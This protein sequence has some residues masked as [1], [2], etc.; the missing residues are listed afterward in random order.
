MRTENLFFDVHPKIVPA[1]QLAKITIRPRYEHVAFPDDAIYRVSH[2]HTE[3]RGLP[4][5]KKP[6]SIKKV[7]PIKGC[8]SFTL[9]F[10]DEQ[11]HVIWVERVNGDERKHVG[12]FRIYSLEKD[13]LLRTPYKGD[14]HI[15]SVRSDG[16]ESPAYVVGAARRIG[17]DFIAVTDHRRY[18]PSLEA[19][20]AFAQAPVDMAIF[21]GEEVH[22]PDN[23]VH[24]I[25]YAG[26]ASINAMFNKKRAYRSAVRQLQQHLPSVPNGVDPYQYASTVWCFNTIREVGGLGVFCHPYWFTA[27]RYTPAGPLT[28]YL[29][30]TQP[31]DAYEVIGGFFRFEADSNTLQVARYHEERAKGRI[32][33]I[34][35]A[36]DAHGCERGELFGWY[37]SIVFSPSLAWQDLRKSIMNLYSVAVEALPNEV[38]RAYGPFRLVKY[39]L[40]LMREAMPQ[41]DELCREEGKLMLDYLAGD[42]DALESLRALSGTTAAYWARQIAR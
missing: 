16:R 18:E 13:L 1:N 42:Q 20:R 4:A 21:P 5:E 24:I 33:P 2:Y 12:N 7:K 37:Y 23:P 6:R 17:M 40:F 39:A 9:P 30:E 10:E 38:P 35:G 26:T 25:N 31:F 34:V 15:H 8:L 3:V 14:F 28:D 41:H 22:P 36:S 19:Q 32:I 11:E 29:F 27:H